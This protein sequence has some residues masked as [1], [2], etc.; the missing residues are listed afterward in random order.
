MGLVV[1]AF[2][3]TLGREVAIKVL[4]LDPSVDSIIEERFLREARAAAHLRHPGIVQVF[5]IDPAG[6][7]IVMELVRGESLS[8]RLDRDK[9]L[10]ADEVRRIGT[11][12]LEALGVAH[13]AGI[14]HRDVKPGNIL[15]G[16]GDEV[17]LADFGVARIGDSELTRPGTQIGTP[18]YM[19]PEQLRGRDVDA[20]AD[21]YAA[22]ATL[23]K[24]VTGNRLHD[25][26]DPKDIVK[27]VIEASGDRVLGEVIARA[28]RE[29][30]ADRF[31]DGRAFAKA[32]ELPVTDVFV[33]VTT[34]IHRPLEVARV[35]TAVP[36]RRRRWP[37]V[38][39]VVSAV[40]ILG[41]LGIG[42]AMRRERT[43]AAVVRTRT[44]ALLPFV[45]DTRVT[46][47]DF[48]S[49]GLP[50]TLGLA[51]TESYGIKLVG[52]YTLRDNMLDPTAPVARWV[53][54]ARTLGAD[55]VVRGYLQRAGAR[56]KVV[57]HVETID[58][59]RL[60][61]IETDAAAEDVPNAVRATA[62]RIAKV[63]AGREVKTASFMPVEFTA[64]RELQLGIAALE[65]ERIADAVEH[66][67]TAVRHAP[68]LAV[69]HYY[70]AF[71]LYWHVRPLDAARTAIDKALSLDLD[72]TQRG[73]LQG[74]RKMVDQDWTGAVPILGGLAER[75]PD[76]RD[77][78][79]VWFEALFHAGR[80]AEAMTVYRRIVKIAPQFRLALEHAFTYYIAHADDAGMSW[81]LA[82]GD[83]AGET[84]NR[85]WEPAILVAR[86]KYEDAIRL[87][88]RSSETATNPDQS[89]QLQRNLIGIHALADRLDR[90]VA[91]ATTLDSSAELLWLAT[92]RGDRE[93]RARSRDAL[94]RQVTSMARGPAQIN[95]WMQLA[96][97]ELPVAT[98]EEL[99]EI[100]N[101]LEAA[102]VADF[103]RTI[104]L[105]IIKALLAEKLGD[106]TQL[107]QLATSP[108][109]EVRELVA[110]A[111][112]R[113]A[114]DRTT[115]AQAT[116]R[117]IALSSD[118]KFLINK[119]WLLAGDLRALGDHEGVR[120]ACDEVIR[121]RQP[122][123]AWGST[124][125]D[126]LAWTAE[127][128]G[129]LGNADEA[130]AAQQRLA[131]LH[132][133]PR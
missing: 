8:A 111:T 60:D 92:A 71:A 96:S 118:A 75:Y 14:V 4:T 32:L 1:E 85:V 88:T 117:A 13:A 66:L 57:L 11:V 9:R 40:A 95:Q 7:Y 89:A 120:T 86:R 3:R 122:T 90:A 78:L 53:E 94:W 29:A 105:G 23:F 70:L 84:Y 31:P 42:V 36:A 43:S 130:R 110:A 119:Y 114:G 26:D 37:L 131:R 59:T 61:A 127:A 16:Q 125:G 115:A 79:Y 62:A 69:A 132:E 126:C 20:R 41:G 56:V 103:S 58:G 19:A 24:A 80:S 5:D 49:E 128:A 83:P 121:A 30:P 55:V 74:L 116:R 98:Q 101:Q 44:V 25:V 51:L 21:V 15:L 99:T 124:V 28:V 6:Q 17:K 2:D 39:A 35:E 22:G 46:T 123:W 27:L 133:P 107:A 64:D 12:V 104:N 73:V 100:A 50:N 108:Y 87:I 72:D 48:T 65:R 112:A 68:T 54:T 129:T 76:H 52:Y 102:L 45:D 82:H 97:A 18:A 91:L 106:A 81:A 34:D 38:A 77:T 109:P 10:P 33:A 47:L 67:Q 93:A 63:V 113:I